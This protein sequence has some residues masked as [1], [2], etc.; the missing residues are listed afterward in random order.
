MQRLEHEKIEKLRGDKSENKSFFAKYVSFKL[1][2]RNIS[3]YI[4]P[5]WMYI[6]PV[7]IFLMI[8]SAANP[9]GQGGGR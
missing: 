6:V 4:S 7:V 5:Q 3:N 9:E 1:R 2:I 8:S